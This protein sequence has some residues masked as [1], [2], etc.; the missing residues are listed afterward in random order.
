MPPMLEEQRR[1]L[2]M[3]HAPAVR[4]QIEAATKWVEANQ[5]TLRAAARTAE[6][7]REFWERAVPPN[8][9]PLDADEFLRV[10]EIAVG[11]GP[12][13]VWAP[14]TEIVKALVAGETF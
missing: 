14:R 12:C 1:A 4:A 10:M 9:R 7:A 5:E 11:H 13:V 2:E 8:L 3:A 6:R